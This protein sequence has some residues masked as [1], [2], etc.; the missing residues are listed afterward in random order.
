M[1]GTTNPKQVHAKVENVLKDDK[2]EAVVCVAGGWA[3]GNAASSD[4]VKNCDLMWK[5]SVWTSVMASQIA[6]HRLSSGGLLLLTGAKAAL[7]GTP[8]NC[9]T[10]LSARIYVY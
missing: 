8:G 3:G 6:A 4:L 5:Q 9:H 2:L 1:L 10:G 7:T